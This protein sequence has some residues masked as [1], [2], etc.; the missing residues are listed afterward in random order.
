MAHFPNVRVFN[1]QVHHNQSS[2][3]T[4]MYAMQHGNTPI[5]TSID[6]AINDTRCDDMSYY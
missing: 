5:P 1:R 3:R 2:S 4:M 6:D